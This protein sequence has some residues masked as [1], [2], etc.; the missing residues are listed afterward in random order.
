MVKNIHKESF[1]T[2]LKINKRFITV[3][4]SII[5]L[6]IILFSGYFFISNKSTSTGVSKVSAYSQEIQGIKETKVTKVRDQLYRQL[7]ERVGP[8]LAQEELL[9]SG[10]PFDGEAHLLNHTV[11]DWLYTEY[12]AKGMI[13]CKDY[14]LSSCYHGF[15]IR[16]IAEHGMGQL[17]EI[18]GECYKVSV[19]TATQC[20]H[21]IGHGLLAWREYK[22]LPQALA[23][24]DTVAT[25]VENFTA[26]NCYDGAFMENNW[27]VHT[28]GKPSPDRWIDL[29]DPSY[30]CY[31]DRIAEKYRKACWSN[32][33]QMAYKDI[34]KGD[35]TQAGQLCTTVENEEYKAT[36]FDSV[37]RQM[38]P[39][40]GNDKNKVVLYCDK[41]PVGWKSLCVISIANSFYS[42]GDRIFPFELCRIL[43]DDAPQ[44]CYEILQHQFTSYP[45]EIIEKR[46]MCSKIPEEYKIEVCQAMAQ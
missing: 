10:I 13:Y 24:C 19:A 2:L 8:T 38:T 3:V 30:P 5:L 14:F 25:L 40:V 27:A 22:N 34:F 23:D 39:L 21:A 17:S 35:L 31:D 20:A 1:L 9:H 46:S 45:L 18:M 41:M 11:G 36:C 6:N 26:Y 29:K 42:M 43:P 16:S 12:D 33:P 15:L 4:I 28:N 44:A 37:A 32:Q 7:I